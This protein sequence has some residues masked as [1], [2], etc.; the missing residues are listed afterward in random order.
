MCSSD[1]RLFDWNRRDA[2]GKSRTLH[3]EQALACIDWARGPVTPI[4]VSGFAAGQPG[5]TRCRQPLVSCPYFVIEYLHETGPFTC[6]GAE[7]L[8]ALLVLQGRGR[9]TTAAGT[10]ELTAGQAWLL[11]ASMPNVQCQAES[12]LKMLLCTLP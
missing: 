1:L 3:V 2:Q 11:P 9:M 12:P 4:C 10:E 6:G 5:T 8:Q 7:R